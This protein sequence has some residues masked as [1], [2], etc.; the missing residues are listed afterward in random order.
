MTKKL[1]LSRLA[2]CTAAIA[3][4]LIL[5]LLACLGFT[6]N[7]AI[8]QARTPLRV[9][10]ITDYD[11][12]EITDPDSPIGVCTRYTWTIGPSPSHGTNLGIYTFHQYVRICVNGVEL[13]RLDAA[14]DAQIVHTPGANWCFFPIY[15]EDAGKELCIE[16]IP[17]YESAR[18]RAPDIYMGTVQDIF[19]STASSELPQILLCI[20]TSFVGLIFL[21]VGLYSFF[22]QNK[23][24]TLIAHGLF[25]IMLGLWK[26]LDL[27]TTNMLFAQDTVALYYCSVCMLALCAVPLMKALS[28]RLSRICRQLINICCVICAV[29][30]IAQLLLQILDIAD[31]RQMLFLTHGS[32]ILSSLVVIPTLIYDSIAYP[33]AFKEQNNKFLLFICVPGALLDIAAF[34][35]TGDSAPLIFTLAAHLIYSI[36]VGTRTMIQTNRQETEIEKSHTAVLRSQIQPHF[37][38]NSLTAIA[39]LCD[40]D[41][42]LAKQATITFSEYYRGNLRAIDRAE[43]ISFAQELEHLKMYLFIEQLRFGDSLKVVFDIE[44][45]DFLI[46]AL[47]IQPLVENAVKHGVGAREEGG[48]VTITVRDLA[49]NY[50]ILI[51]DD[52]VGFDPAKV[53]NRDRQHVGI[54]NVKNRLMLMC[55]ASL[56]IQSTLGE[57]TTITISLP[58]EGLDL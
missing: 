31:M 45:T 43:P 55:D 42:A 28:R 58:K 29:S 7:T 4:I 8:Y 40:K 30:C 24:K 16:I 3:A 14:S 22:T 6:K 20:L 13:Y 54:D 56:R 37:L 10:P 2:L 48:T 23:G 25:S 36:V 53:E 1:S 5:A 57:G 11:R 39:Q 32:I 19:L 9:V 49:D 26:L 41:P 44:T 18:Q 47:T 51:S 52:G 33:R 12:E 21:I 46:P 27:R 50:L 38:F 15:Q 17:A 34:Y 35:F